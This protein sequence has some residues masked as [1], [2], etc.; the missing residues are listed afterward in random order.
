[1]LKK[2]VR[3]PVITLL[4]LLAAGFC[5]GLLSLWFAAGSYYIPMFLSYWKHPVLAA[6]NVLPVMLLVLLFWLAVRRAWLAFLLSGGLVMVF[7][8]S[9]FYKLTFRDDPLMFEDVLL[10]KEVG[11]MM[12]KYDLFLSGSM[13][14]AIA[15]VLFGAVFLAFFARARLD[16]WE[17]LGGVAAALLALLCLKGAISSDAVYD[18]AENYDLINRWSATQ[19]YLSK[20]FVY[21]FLHSAADAFDPLPEG[22]EEQRAASILAAY[23]DTDIPDGEKVNLITV[24]LESYNDFTKF[25][26]AGLSDD[27]YAGY[28]ALEA[29]SVTGN[30]VTNIFAG[31]TV[32]TERSFLTG[33]ATLGSF[34]SPTNSYAWYFNGQG[35]TVEG[36]HPCY[37]WFYNRLNINANLGFDRYY[38]VENYYGALTGGGIAYDDVLFPQLISL[39][40][41]NRDNTES[42]LFSFNVTYQGHGPYND[43]VTWW[44][45][46]YL[47]GGDFTQAER[48]ILNNYF[49]SIANTTQNLTAFFDYFRNEQEP[50][51]IVLYG[52]HNPWLGDGNSVY[53]ALGIDLDV[54][55]EAGFRNYYTTR[56]LIWANE[57]AKEALQNDFVGEGPD[58]SPCFLMNEVFRLCGW[59]GPAY[60]QATQQ[61]MDT[62]PVLHAT[63]LYEEH[64]TITDTL[65]SEDAA[66]VQDY[67]WL[68]YYWRT[69]YQGE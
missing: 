17:R 62:V 23:E 63:G 58:L 67:R 40:E 50:V 60:M 34:R 14:L 39:Y 61:V 26:L 19:V 28:H 52:D 13:K 31:G 21:P 25:N 27:V 2:I 53:K 18:G 9:N 16:R 30:L 20:G 47:T 35:Y 43:D 11:S 41:E 55:T 51:V 57:A 48:N 7:T 46:D 12:G 15:L 36:S 4:L 69:H 56:Y 10:L 42:P 49:G 6:L 64:D 38:F 24:Q 1:M 22:Y 8:F 68:Q 33:F 65:T 3:S 66:L 54:T 45:D 44:G 5:L 32:D 29:E 59:D 37:D